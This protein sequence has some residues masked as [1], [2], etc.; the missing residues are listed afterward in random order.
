MTK[1][2]TDI[3][4]DSHLTPI[5]MP[6]ECILGEAPLRRGGSPI[7]VYAF[8]MVCYAMWVGHHPFEASAVLLAPVS[9]CVPHHDSAGQPE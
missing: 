7:D 3:G 1:L 5:Y 8:G 2:R 6:P 4:G 9:Q